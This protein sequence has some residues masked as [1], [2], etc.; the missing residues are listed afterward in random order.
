MK[1][2]PV[3]LEVA[4]LR[5]CRTGDIEVLRRIPTRR[6]LEVRDARGASG[7]HYAARGGQLHAM[8]LLVAAGAIATRTCVGATPL[9]DAAVLGQLSAIR[10]LLA[11]TRCSLADRDMEGCNALH[12]AAR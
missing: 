8:A 3:Q 1:R 12:L 11:H 4:V 7:L 2:S 10:W 9:H 6:L 5:A